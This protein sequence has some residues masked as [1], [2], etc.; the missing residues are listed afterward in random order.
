MPSQPVNRY[1]PLQL[2]LAAFVGSL[3]FGL[4]GAIL[5]DRAARELLDGERLTVIGGDIDILGNGAGDEG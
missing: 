3:A 2:V 1:A 4:A 5:F